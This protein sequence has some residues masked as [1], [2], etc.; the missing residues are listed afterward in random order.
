MKK[1]VQMI[2]PSLVI[3]LL[4]LKAISEAY[5]FVKMI[6]IVINTAL[7][8]SVMLK[9]YHQNNT[10]HILVR[11]GSA[12]IIVTFFIMFLQSLD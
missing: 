9:K 6:I 1:K 11:I 2:A 10:K 4:S 12:I 5:T 3:A 7:F 8:L